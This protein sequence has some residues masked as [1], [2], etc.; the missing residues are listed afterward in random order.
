MPA[1]KQNTADPDGYRLIIK[2]GPAGGSKFEFYASDG[3]REYF[4]V[5]GALKG[6]KKLI[7]DILT[8][9]SGCWPEKAFSITYRS[10][11]LHEISGISSIAPSIGAKKEPASDV[12]EATLIEKYRRL[13]P[14]DQ[15]SILR[16]VAS[17]PPKN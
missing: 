13:P 4:F 3:R 2:N 9:I 8:I 15:Q 11:T 5:T 12:D 17:L 6:K 16:I 7:L 10:D 14:E 1:D